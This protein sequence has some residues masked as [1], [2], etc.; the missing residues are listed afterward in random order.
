MNGADL[1]VLVVPFLDGSSNRV[2]AGT[3]LE[4]KVGLSSLMLLLLLLSK[5]LH[6]WF[7]R[8]APVVKSLEGQVLPSTAPPTPW[9]YGG[10]CQVGRVRVVVLQGCSFEGTLPLSFQLSP[11]PYRISNRQYRALCRSCG[12]SI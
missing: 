1:A 12:A 5:Q 8:V 6:R 10:W 9:P 7:S 11:P 4:A 2:E 3:D